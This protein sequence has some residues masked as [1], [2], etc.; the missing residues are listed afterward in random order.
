LEFAEHPWIQPAT[1]LLEPY[2]SAELLRMVK[3]ALSANAGVGDEIAP[4]PIL[5]SQPVLHSQ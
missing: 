5:K 1:M 2:S 4:S 3:E